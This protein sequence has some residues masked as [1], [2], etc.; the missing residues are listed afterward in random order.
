MPYAK[1]KAENCCFKNGRIS[2][3]DEERF[4]R[5]STVT[6]T[7]NVENARQAIVEDR[8]RTIYDVRNIVKL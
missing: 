4:R 2:V 8:W 6:T 7:V 1:R 3:D 5:P